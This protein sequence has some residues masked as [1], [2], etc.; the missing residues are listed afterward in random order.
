MPWTARTFKKHNAHLTGAA[1]SKAA[2]VAT[3]A[4]KSGVPEGE[5]IAIGNTAGNRFRARQRK[6]R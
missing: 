1:L 2:K 6:R 4:L 5:A 3:G